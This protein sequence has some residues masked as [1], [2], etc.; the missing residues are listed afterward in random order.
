MN[1]IRHSERSNVRALVPESDCANVDE[2][3]LV[4]QIENQILIAD[5]IKLAV[6]GLAKLESSSGI[7]A[8]IDMHVDRLREICDQLAEE[9]AIARHTRVQS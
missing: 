1:A 5:A 2:L 4:D 6:I 3:G 7:V 8:L 9:T